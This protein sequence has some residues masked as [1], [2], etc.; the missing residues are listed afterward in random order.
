MARLEGC[1]VSFSV[2]RRRGIFPRVEF[3]LDYWLGGRRIRFVD[4][5]STHGD[6]DAGGH[7][8][9]SSELEGLRSSGKRCSKKT[10][11]RIDWT[12]ASR[13]LA[14]CHSE[15][16]ECASS[17][18]SPGT[19][20]AN[21][22]VI[23]VERRC[24][25]DTPPPDRN[26]V[27]LSYVWGQSP[28][29]TKLHATKSNMQRLL[30]DGSLSAAKMPRTVEDA[31]EACRRLGEP[32][33]WVDRFCI[34][35][36]DAD[37]KGEQIAAMGA[38]YSLAKLVLLATD[39]HSDS[40]IAG[41]SHDRPQKQ[42]SYQIA[43]ITFTNAPVGWREIINGSSAWSTRGWTY[44]EAILPTR[45]LYLTES[46]AF[47][48]CRRSVLSEDGSEEMAIYSPLGLRNQPWDP[49][50]DV[51]Y[52][53]VSRYRARKLTN[54]S[55]IYNAIDGVAS[56]L[57]GRFGSLWAGLPRQDFD[58]AL[59]WSQNGLDGLAHRNEHG[60]TYMYPSWSWSSI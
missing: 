8:P 44:Q 12:Q 45:K 41:V 14:E 30:V 19:L 15:H 58:R 56:A 18:T 52:G 25:V 3:G 26:F 27:A 48:E 50:V 38:V 24:I 17:G 37:D 33:L 23:D 9:G 32:Y 2:R 16:D 7:S 39:G 28:D 59:L 5:L 57:Y 20:P 47:F 42:L 4:P 43:G 46:Q 35:Q 22:R 51:L 36:D 6:G 11:A 53:H 55:D 49:A 10:S 60:K 13:W 31:M 40:G 1:V 29:P 54:L 21:F 34:V